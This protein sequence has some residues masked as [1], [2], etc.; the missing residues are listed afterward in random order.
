MSSMSIA[1]MA[2]MASIPMEKGDA[3]GKASSLILATHDDG[4]PPCDDAPREHDDLYSGSI[5]IADCPIESH[6]EM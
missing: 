6:I 4:V 2:S 5:S 3:K 1:C